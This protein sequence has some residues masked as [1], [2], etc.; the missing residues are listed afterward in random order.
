MTRYLKILLSFLFCLVMATAVAC[1]ENPSASDSSAS[2]SVSESVS[3][4]DSTQS[5]AS[6]SE[7]SDSSDSSSDSPVKPE[8][9]LAGN[10]YVGFQTVSQGMT[11]QVTLTLG[12]DSVCHL[13]Y[14]GE[15]SGVSFK[16]EYD[17]TYMQIS[18][19]LIKITMSVQGNTGS[20][21]AR[22]YT[23][24]TF[25]FTENI[26]SGSYSGRYEEGSIVYEIIVFFR[27]DNTYY[28]EYTITFSGLTKNGVSEGTYSVEKDVYILVSEDR[29][30]PLYMTLDEETMTLTICSAPD[31]PPAQ[32]TYV[33]DLTTPYG[34][35]SLTLTLCDEENCTLGYSLSAMGQQYTD[36]FT[37]TYTTNADGTLRLS[38][39]DYP[40]YSVTVSLNQDGT[41]EIIASSDPV[42]PPETDRVYTGTVTLEG[43]G[44]ITLTLYL[45]GDS[46]CTV[47]Y[48]VFVMDQE[49]GG[50][51]EATYTV[52]A[53][54]T[55]NL[56]ISEFNDATIVLE[57][58][59]DGTFEV[60][61]ATVPDVDLEKT[62]EHTFTLGKISL[63]VYCTVGL[64]G[65]TVGYDLK[66]GSWVD[67]S[68]SIT[69]HIPVTA[70]A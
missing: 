41:F 14:E 38:I 1:T 65:V 70:I 16:Q 54:G 49:Y 31:T 43:V 20:V 59:D 8:D 5:E 25:E 34:T 7:T 30:E 27:P 51:T 3:S 55:I 23:D 44:E 61:G 69:L 13:L 52:N 18:E 19:D 42:T 26:T 63:R 68:H 12:Q 15:Y 67:T 57:L 4:S 32:D 10:S 56:T 28:M 66:V 24:G 48:S 58:F 11:M 35:V 17:G 53:D 6:S 9:P 47:A 2:A 62:Y 33:C 46:D 36:E 22:L 60:V 40:E 45:T 29:P 64:D 50:T 37:G 21:Y 39:P